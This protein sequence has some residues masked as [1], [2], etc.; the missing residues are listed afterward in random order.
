MAQEESESSHWV[1]SADELGR[2]TE[3]F[4]KFDGALD[5]TAIEPREAQIEFRKMLEIIYTEKVKP[6]FLSI[7]FNAFLRYARIE[8]RQRAQSQF[9]QFPSP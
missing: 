9:R 4:I 7:D 2:L 8:C 6:R 3:L 1:V 5:P